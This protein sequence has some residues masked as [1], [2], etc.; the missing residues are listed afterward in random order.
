[1]EHKNITD[2]NNHVASL[3]TNV[4]KAV[5]INTENRRWLYVCNLMTTATK[6]HTVKLVFYIPWSHVFLDSTYIF[7]GQIETSVTTKFVLSTHFLNYT[8]KVKTNWP[9]AVTLSTF[10]WKKLKKVILISCLLHCLCVC[11][12]FCGFKVVPVEQSCVSYWC[13]ACHAWQFHVVIRSVSALLFE[14]T[15]NRTHKTVFYFIFWSWYVISDCKLPLLVSC[16]IS[17]TL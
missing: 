11:S 15:K 13:K 9:V 12:L 7:I 16:C 14:S 6:V 17:T 5:K 8:F 2:C 10:N 4:D 1:M 3:N